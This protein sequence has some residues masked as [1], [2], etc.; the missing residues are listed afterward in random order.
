M[1][2]YFVELFSNQT[3]SSK[4]TRQC[5]KISYI[6]ALNIVNSYLICQYVYDQTVLI[7]DVEESDS[8]LEL[9]VRACILS[10]LIRAVVYPAMHLCGHFR[11]ALCQTVC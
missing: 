6:G 8:S 7:L 3:R 9:V 2:R 1:F 10:K 11:Q 4:L 5:H